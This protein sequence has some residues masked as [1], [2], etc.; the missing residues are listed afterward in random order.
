VINRIQKLYHK[1]V[2]QINN[3]LYLKILGIFLFP[4]AGVSCGQDNTDIIE[5]L[6]SRLQSREVTISGI[7][8]DTSLMHLHPR[9]SFREMIKQYADTGII[10]ITAGSEPGVKT[11][12]QCRVVDEGGNRLPGALVYFYQTSDKGWYSDTGAHILVNSGDFKH[13]RLFG[14]TKTNAEG[15][16]NIETI[17]PS[18]YPNSDLPA[19]IHVHVTPQDES[20]EGAGTE[21]L[22]EEDERLTPERKERSIEDG[23]L[24]AKSTGTP[25][26]PYYYYEIVIRKK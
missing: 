1:N 25:E 14:Y 23:F 2:K 11:T 3:I 22:F 15:Y 18:G 7:L 8:T 9:T 17:R 20:L 24:V 10:K 5:E 26:K 4:L 21:F 16:I 12:V 19:H 13:A 6:K